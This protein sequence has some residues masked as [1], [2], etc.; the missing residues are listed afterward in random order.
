MPRPL[1]ATHDRS[2][3]NCDDLMWLCQLDRT[4]TVIIFCIPHFSK[5][6]WTVNVNCSLPKSDKLMLNPSRCK[7]LSFMSFCW[8]S[9]ALWTA[10]VGQS[11]VPDKRLHCQSVN[12]EQ[13]RLYWYSELPILWSNH[14]NGCDWQSYHLWGTKRGDVNF[15]VAIHPWSFYIVHSLPIQMNFVAI[16]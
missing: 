12:L 9:T 4:H 15:R 13:P 16:L 7:S 1:L 6:L 8:W 14:S 11:V 10:I 3:S 5:V 2:V